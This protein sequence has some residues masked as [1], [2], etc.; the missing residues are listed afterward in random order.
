MRKITNL[1][2]CPDDNVLYMFLSMHG[3]YIDDFTRIESV[4]NRHQSAYI[5]CT[6]NSPRV[7]F[8]VQEIHH[9]LN[10]VLHGVSQRF[11]VAGNYPLGDWERA[12]GIEPSG[13][14][15]GTRARHLATLA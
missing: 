11:M 7:K 12:E 2:S 10:L 14:L 5:L 6:G 9:E 1:K 4:I 3:V 13:P 15:V 8:Y